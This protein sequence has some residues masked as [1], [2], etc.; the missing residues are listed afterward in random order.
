[1]YKKYSDDDMTLS[2]VFRKAAKYQS[3]Y[4]ISDEEFNL[5]MEY[6]KHFHNKTLSKVPKFAFSTPFSKLLGMAHPSHVGVVGKM[7]VSDEDRKTLSRIKT[8]LDGDRAL[9]ATCA[10]QTSIYRDPG[11]LIQAQWNQGSASQRVDCHFNPVLAAFFINKIQYVDDRMLMSNLA[12][13]INSR[14]KNRNPLFWQDVQFLIDLT[15]STNDMVC[16]P[17]NLM[18]DLHHRCI[19]Q[20]K[21]REL[22]LRFR[23][24]QVFHPQFQSF[25]SILN[26][27]KMSSYDNPHMA[28]FNDEGRM[29]RKIM[30]VFCMRPIK[31][32]TKPINGFGPIPATLPYGLQEVKERGSINVKIPLQRAGAGGVPVNMFQSLRTPEWYMSNRVM[33]ARSHEILFSQGMLVFY[34][35]R[36]TPQI[37]YANQQF[38]YRQMAL[39]PSGIDR[40]NDYPVEVNQIFNLPNGDQYQLETVV[41][42]KCTQNAPGTEEHIV[43]TKTLFIRRPDA[44]AAQQYY[45]YDPLDVI[46]QSVAGAGN[47]RPIQQYPR[48]QNGNA[49]QE[50]EDEASKY[51]TIFVYSRSAPFPRP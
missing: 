37:A 36:R 11:I 12:D 15:R 8:I 42:C 47:P 5:F 34:V 17:K 50:W 44:A 49:R 18:T 10:T 28:Y 24:G 45:Q 43:G 31:I 32:A 27:C 25:M 16:N 23:A 6:Y 22:V 21:L 9:H 30:E 2:K 51:G 14:S 1:M 39:Q 7:N 46:R 38:G 48:A 20:T 4:G 33:S 40:L 41:C 13:V 19:V 3:E 29:L 26:G 35:N